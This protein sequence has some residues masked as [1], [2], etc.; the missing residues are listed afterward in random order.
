VSDDLLEEIRSLRKTLARISIRL[1]ELESQAALRGTVAPVA[2]PSVVAPPPVHRVP[3]TPTAA[4]TPATAPRETLELTIGRYWLNRLGILSLVLGTA[5]FLVYSFQY[6]GPL[7]KIAMG[8]GVG[9][10]L[11]VL[12]LRLERKPGLA[13]YALGLMGG[14]WAV[15]YFTTYAMYHVPETKILGSAPVDLA[16]LLIV[17]A[18]AVRHALTKRSQTIT[19]LAFLLGFLT[20]G[21]SEVTSFTFASSIILIGSLVVLAARSGWHGLLLYGLIGSYLTH[22]VA[23]QQHI[24]RAAPGILGGTPA[25]SF[26]W[27]D[28]AFMTL[29]AVGYSLGVLAMDEREERRRDVLLATTVVNG[30]AYALLLLPVLRSAYPG[31]T[32]IALLLMGGVSLLFSGVASRRGLAAVSSAHLFLGLTFATIA[33]PLKLTHRA[34]SLFWFAEVA[35]LSALGV[36]FQRWVYRLFALLLGLAALLWVL[37]VELFHRDRYILQ[38]WSLSW[39]WIVA[40]SAVLAYSIAAFASRRLPVERY[41]WPWESQSFHLFAVAA[42][43]TLWTVTVTTNPA[44]RISLL[45]AIEATGVTLLGWGIRDRGIRLLGFLWF[46]AP[47]A[48]VLASFVAHGWIWS[49]VTALTVVV[50]LYAMAT[51]YRRRPPEPSFGPEAHLSGFHAV[52]AS[53]LLAGVLWHE[54]ASRWLTLGWA[55]EGLVLV[56]IGFRLPDKYYR[57]SGLAI[58]SLLLLKILFVDLAAA[59]TIWRILSFV[60]AGTILL[61]ASYGYAKFNARETRAADPP[62]TPPA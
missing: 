62:T 15:L 43:I 12:G 27:L 22:V 20:T 34:T 48:V 33:I 23:V 13:W 19:M 21:I 50:A 9:A 39:P 53:L 36:R 29:I 56:V 17:A 26:F 7:A 4:V 61:L 14:G 11:L 41:R 59:E 6:L 10:G 8:Y 47:I 46:L 37:P 32:W 60:A 16:L 24:V 52:T 40:G 42:G 25:Q 57:V 30:W 1:E 51:L 44:H 3:A 45:W 18:G 55:L 2:A 54:L 31:T 49:R 35:V 58:F 38:G 5:F 28:A